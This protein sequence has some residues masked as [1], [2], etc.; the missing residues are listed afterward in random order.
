MNL[1]WIWSL[2]V[3]MFLFGFVTDAFGQDQARAPISTD[4]PSFTTDS[5]IVGVGDIQLELGYTYTELENDTHISTFPEALL[6][7]GLNEKWELRLG[8]DGYAFS[9]DVN[10]VDEEVAGG[11]DFGFKWRFK[12]VGE[13]GL[14]KISMALITTFTLPTGHIHN[15][16]DYEFLLGWNYQIDDKTSLAG[17]LG[18]GAPTDIITGDRYAKGIASIMCSKALSD[19]ASIFGEIY[20]NFPASDDGDAEY[21][22]QT[23]LVHRLGN[24]MQLD[25]RVGAGLNDDSPDWLVGLGFAYRF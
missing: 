1:Q 7:Y 16:F 17:S 5:G 25:F 20:T 11:T 13:Q 19:E 2:V 10:G 12:D 6:R 15:D 3:A 4:R 22:F 8:W 21:V 14:D 9:E 18:V 24:D 23:G